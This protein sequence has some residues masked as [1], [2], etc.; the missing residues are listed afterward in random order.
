M[1]PTTILRKVPLP[2]TTLLL[3][4]VASFAEQSKGNLSQSTVW[5]LQAWPW[6]AAAAFLSVI[7][8]SALRGGLRR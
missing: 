2:L 5:Y 6:V 3:S 4:N 8:V 7:V 1:K